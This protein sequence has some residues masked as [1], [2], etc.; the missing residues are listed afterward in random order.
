MF[1]FGQDQL[2]QTMKRNYSD[3]SCVGCGGFDTGC[4]QEKTVI[5]VSVI[6]GDLVPKESGYRCKVRVAESAYAFANEKAF[7][8]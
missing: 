6:T 1:I 8:K 5:P 7:M 2:G 3:D 4:I